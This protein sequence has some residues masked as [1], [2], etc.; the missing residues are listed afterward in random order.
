M[1]VVAHSSD[2]QESRLRT[3]LVLTSLVFVVQALGGWFTGSLAL[4]SDAGHVLTDVGGLALA[5]M[6]LRFA[7]RP[8]TPAKTFGFH[9]AEIL[10]ALAN[11]VVLLALSF[12]ILYEAWR[13]LIEP[14]E[15]QGLPVLAIALFGLVVNLY[16]VFT[17][18]EG[19]AHSLNMRGAFFEVLGDALS[20][21]A[22]IA[23]ALIMLTTGW[24]YADPVFGIVIALFIFPR[25]WK[26][27]REAVDILLEATPKDVDQRQVVEMIKAQPHVR[28][29]HELHIWTLSSQN[30]SLSAHV[31]FDHCDM[32]RTNPIVNEIKQALGERFLIRHATL[33]VE[34][35][36]AVEFP[37]E[38]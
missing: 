11:A 36:H 34:C 2:R 23:A 6:A 16:G 12:V 20:S 4:I 35:P 22:V 15:L 13:R 24:Y 14:P 37:Q 5:L 38:H 26:L 19:A 3:T 28:D 25:T 30:Y 18:R 31:V 32:E 29:V 17:L 7:R 33:E 21:I 1:S 9:R 8:A 10:A 27:L